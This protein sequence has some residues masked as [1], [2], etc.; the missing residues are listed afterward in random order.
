MFNRLSARMARV[1]AL[2]TCSLALAGTAANPAEAT[3]LVAGGQVSLVAIEGD[4]PNP[5]PGA[6]FPVQLTV[7]SNSGNGQLFDI[8]QL[9]VFNGAG[10]CISCGW[11]LDLSKF[12]ID[13]VSMEL[14]GVLTGTLKSGVNFD[15]V[16]GTDLTWTYQPQA[17]GLVTITGIIDAPTVDAVPEPTSLALLGTALFGFGLLRR[18]RYRL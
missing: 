3:P 6:A 16:L 15:V 18:R 11:Q 8:T 4:S 13:E 10:Q 2:I 17:A 9:T 14:S 5:R 1:F 7:G 12:F